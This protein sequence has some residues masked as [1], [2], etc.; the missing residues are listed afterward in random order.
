MTNILAQCI[1][2]HGTPQISID[3]AIVL[4]SREGG[5]R[6]CEAR[7]AVLDYLG[8]QREELC[9]YLG[10]TVGT[11]DKYWTRIYATTGKH[12]REVTRSWVEELLARGVSEA[13]PDTT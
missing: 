13:P 7:I 12:G 2:L 9:E 5:I 11:I 6:R 10:V 8:W 3:A 4:I 1:G